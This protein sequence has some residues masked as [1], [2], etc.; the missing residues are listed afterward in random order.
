[1]LFPAY[2]HV[3]VPGGVRHWDAVYADRLTHDGKLQVNLELP[4]L[5]VGFDGVIVKTIDHGRGHWDVDLRPNGDHTKIEN[6]ITGETYM[7]LDSMI[8][9]KVTPP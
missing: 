6:P 2:T 4:V 3:R 9:G 8:E 1:M 7:F 5:E